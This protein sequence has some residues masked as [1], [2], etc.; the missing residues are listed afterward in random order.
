MLAESGMY[1]SEVEAESGRYVLLALV[2]VRYVAVDDAVVR[3]E[4]EAA[5]QIGSVS[6]FTYASEVDAESGRY[7]EAAVAVVRYGER[8]AEVMNPDMELFAV[9][10]SCPLMLVM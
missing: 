4:D 7:V 5:D 6:V 3:Y 8:A 10:K 1:E 2:I 9:L